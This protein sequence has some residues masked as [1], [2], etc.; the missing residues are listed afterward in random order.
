MRKVLCIWKQ[1][2]CTYLSP[3]SQGTY[4]ISPSA[5]LPAALG[6]TAF[7]YF[8]LLTWISSQLGEY[9]TTSPIIG[10]N[11]TLLPVL[12]EVLVVMACNGTVA[13]GLNQVQHSQHY[14]SPESDRLLNRTPEVWT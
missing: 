10:G 7:W 14:H 8:L 11:P 3:A 12:G 4:F 2:N 6:K 5:Y 13:I 9:N 1:E